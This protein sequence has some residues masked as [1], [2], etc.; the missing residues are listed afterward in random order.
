MEY[1]NSSDARQT[2]Q[3]ATVLVWGLSKVTYPDGNF[4]TFKYK[5]DAYFTLLI[6]EINYT[7]N[8]EASLSPY[9]QIRFD[10]K[11]RTVDGNTL[12]EDNTRIQ[13]KHLLDKITVKAE[14]ATV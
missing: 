3:Y 2:G 7:G 4:M 1:G 10:Y 5:S 6:E 12:Y 14:D 9:N 8:S 11:V 13:N